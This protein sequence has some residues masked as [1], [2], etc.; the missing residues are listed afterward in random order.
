M[1]NTDDAL[2]RYEQERLEMSE[3]PD[4]RTHFEGCEWSHLDCA[5]RML[6]EAQAEI[7]RRKAESFEELRGDVYKASLGR[8]LRAIEL[9][10]ADLAAMRPVVDAA[11][12]WCAA[13][14]APWHGVVEAE[15]E[16]RASVL[17]YRSTHPAP[18]AQE[19]NT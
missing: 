10:N 19:K 2:A 12:A 18:E 16:L 3:Q 6:R 9:L 14:Q 8:S 5:V 13:A 11:V 15:M 17:M 7:E 1:T 4:G